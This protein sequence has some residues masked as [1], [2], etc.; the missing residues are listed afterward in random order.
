VIKR[1]EEEEIAA[2]NNANW[3]S[4]IGLKIGRKGLLLIA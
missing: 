1:E 3:S 4:N 2:T